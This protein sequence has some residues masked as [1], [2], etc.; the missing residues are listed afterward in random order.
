MAE[1]MKVTPQSYRFF[2][3]KESDDEKELDGKECLWA[4]MA[5]WKEN[6][7]L[8]F[9]K[10]DSSIDTEAMTEAPRE[11][12]DDDDNISIYSIDGE[13][14]IYYG[15]DNY[16]GFVRLF[17]I[18]YFFSAVS[19]PPSLPLSRLLQPCLGWRDNHEAGA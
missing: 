8:L 2:E 18:V 13:V 7:K 9:K 10:I 1:Q 14:V 5:N 3:L 17:F 11:S 4:L 6:K 16:T 19:Y 12:V 15:A